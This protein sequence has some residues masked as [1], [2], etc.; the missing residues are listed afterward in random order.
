MNNPVQTEDYRGYEIRV[1][2]DPEPPNPRTDY[3]N[4]GTMVCF[5]KRYSLG[6]QDHGYKSTDFPSWAAVEAQL[7]KDYR[8]PVILPV[9]MYDHSGLT[10]NTTGFS[11]PWDSGQIGYIVCSLKTAKT[12]FGVKGQIRK[13]WQGQAAYT[14]NPDGS[15]R[16]LREAVEHC[17][18][19]EVKSYDDYL[20]NNC[21]GFVVDN[22]DDEDSC[23]GFLGDIEYCLQEARSSVDSRQ[24]EAPK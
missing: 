15:S 16:T 23:W 2:E 8:D 9:Y 12:E 22:G 7:R 5:H 24:V 13:G 10:I 21:W 19:Q 18:L 11:C 1:Y 14:P 6:D 17:L 20:T 3:G 4:V